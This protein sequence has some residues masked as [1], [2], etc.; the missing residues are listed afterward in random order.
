MQAGKEWR[1]VTKFL[2][3]LCNADG[4]E[5]QVGPS[6]DC[7]SLTEIDYSMFNVKTGIIPIGLFERNTLP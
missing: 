5:I 3:K 1:V 6:A 2:E 4:N 7:E